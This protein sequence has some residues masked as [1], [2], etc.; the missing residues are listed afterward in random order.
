MHAELSSLTDSDLVAKVIT[1]VSSDCA[2]AADLLHHLGEVDARRLYADAGFSSMFAW[3][4][5]KLGMCESSAGRRIAAARAARQFPI[6][7][8][9]VSTGRIHVTG[10]AMLAPHLTDDNHRELL[11]A[12]CGKTRRQ[13]E[14]VLADRNPKPDVRPL[15][16]KEPTPSGR[17]ETAA[18]SDPPAP[19]TNRPTPPPQPLGQ[20]RYKVQFTASKDLRDKLERATALMSHRVEP[21]DL[22][23]VVEAAV[24]LLI[25]QVEK[26]RFAAQPK[27]KRQTKPASKRTRHI[28]NDIKRKVYTRDEGQCTFRA[29][30]GTRCTSRHRLE[31][32]HKHPWGKQGEHAVD[33]IELRC[34]A[35]NQ[36]AARRDFEAAVVE[37]HVAQSSSDRRPNALPLTCH[38]PQRE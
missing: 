23:A 30:D 8:E 3:C 16:R 9:L 35:H 22:A 10:V 21:G 4:T 36:L 11:E 1:L 24:D 13:L 38:A 12:G 19:P 17:P 18:V 2:L 29:P 27:T 37:A 15:M 7:L 14:E 20:Q 5:A 33:N 25:E 34:R 31:L 6:I 26:E 28:P 32:H